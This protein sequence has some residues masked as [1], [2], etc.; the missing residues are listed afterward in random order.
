MER[1]QQRPRVAT[2][3]EGTSA[4]APQ[5]TAVPSGSGSDSQ[6]ILGRLGCPPDMMVRCWTPPGELSRRFVQLDDSLQPIFTPTA[7]THVSY[8]HLHY[9]S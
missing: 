4:G 1:P 7:S 2:A 9:L 3:G 8:S 6:A 5:G